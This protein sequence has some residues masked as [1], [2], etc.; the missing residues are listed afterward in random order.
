MFIIGL[1]VWGILSVFTIVLLIPKKCFRRW[2][3]HYL[4]EIN[5]DQRQP[6]PSSLPPTSLNLL[7]ISQFPLLQNTPMSD[8]FNLTSPLRRLPLL[9]NTLPSLMSSLE[10]TPLVSSRTV[11]RH[12]ECKRGKTEGL[13]E[14]A[15]NFREK[16]ADILEVD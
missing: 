9:F 3:N 12:K 14:L 5:S 1:I 15:R 4:P 8:P 2:M 16:K 11:I 13:K 10:T 7:D 6:D